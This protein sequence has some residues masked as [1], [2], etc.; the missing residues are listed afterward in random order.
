MPSD[1][2]FY[3]EFTQAKTSEDSIAPFY[4]MEFED[5]IRLCLLCENT[6]WWIFV[7]IPYTSGSKD[8]KSRDDLVLQFFKETVRIY[9]RGDLTL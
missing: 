4:K 2:T 1:S 7:V 8:E 5:F 6:F 9:I 3:Q